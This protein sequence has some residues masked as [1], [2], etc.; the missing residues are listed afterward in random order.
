MV[1]ETV[2][3]IVSPHI[4]KWAHLKDNQHCHL[5]VDESWNHEWVNAEGLLHRV[6]E[7]G[8]QDGPACIIF[9]R[10]INIGI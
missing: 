9:S 1:E 5:V 4:E 10:G 2:M 8:V 3:Q 6:D 7:S